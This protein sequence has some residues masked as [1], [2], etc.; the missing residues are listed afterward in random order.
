MWKNRILLEHYFLPGDLEKPDA[1]RCLLRARTINTG[2]QRKDQEKDH[3]EAS[4]AL[5]A[6]RRV[7]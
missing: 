4:V 1:S 3:R 5:S 7:N 6:I 2:K